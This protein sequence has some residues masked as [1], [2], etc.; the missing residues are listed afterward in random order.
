[1]LNLEFLTD[2]KVYAKERKKTRVDFVRLCFA[3][4]DMPLLYDAQVQL[5][6]AIML[7]LLILI[8]GKKLGF[9]TLCSLLTNYAF[10]TQRAVGEKKRSCVVQI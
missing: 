7:P 6:M 2:L 1:M 9:P 4:N 3:G 5:A 10:G 8:L